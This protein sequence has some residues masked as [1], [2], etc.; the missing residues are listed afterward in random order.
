V[1]GT[2]RIGM[3]KKPAELDPLV[4]ADTGV[5]GAAGGIVAGKAVDDVLKVIGQVEWIKRNVQ[6]IGHPPGVD[7]IADA[8]TALMAGPGCGRLNNWQL[9]DCCRKC[10]LAVPHEDPDALMTGL[11]QQRRGDAGI[12]AARHGNHNA[13]H[14]VNWA[15]IAVAKGR[16]RVGS[17]MQDRLD[18]LAREPLTAAKATELDEE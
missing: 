6:P 3:V 4:T 2:D 8:A 5:R 18:S 9:S 15:G 12:D 10:R 7:C 17:V 1:A 16:C 11:H 13:G 14:G